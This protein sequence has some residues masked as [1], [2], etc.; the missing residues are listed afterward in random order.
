MKT[1]CK[2]L[3]TYLKKRIDKSIIFTSV[4]LN[5][6]NRFVNINEII[7]VNNYFWAMIRAKTSAQFD[8]HMKRFRKNFFEI[9][10][11][12]ETINS[13]F[14]VAVYD[15]YY[16]WNK[17]TNDIVEMINHILLKARSMNEFDL[18]SHIW[19]R[20]MS[21]RFNR[22]IIAKQ[23]YQTKILYI[24]YVNVLLNKSKMH[25]LKFTIKLSIFNQIKIIISHDYV[26]D[27]QINFINY[28]I[29]CNC[30]KFQVLNV[31]CDHVLNFFRH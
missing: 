1:S 7:V 5:I 26:Y 16:R 21:M 30:R 22:W 8:L 23:M 31:F 11:K 20:I 15:S 18:L 24:S 10:V 19:N 14:Y 25:F 12:F 9:V 17:N 27:I 6:V 2:I 3:S 13:T 4:F 29:E 28:L